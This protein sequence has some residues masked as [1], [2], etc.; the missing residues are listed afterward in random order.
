MADRIVDETPR[1]IL[2]PHRRLVKQANLSHCWRRSSARL[3][4]G[5]QSET[6]CVNTQGNLW[7]ARDAQVR[8][9]L[10]FNDILLVRTS[11]HSL[12]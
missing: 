5:D 4:M 6:I 11:V 1:L 9:V 2:K 12:S 10:L 7:L 3:P 8:T